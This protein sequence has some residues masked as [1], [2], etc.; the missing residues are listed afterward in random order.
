MGA[1]ELGNE[2]KKKKKGK[3]FIVVWQG[4]CFSS[5]SWAHGS[6][7]FPRLPVSD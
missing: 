3:N 6:T 2:K 4:L 1:K 5:A 7:E